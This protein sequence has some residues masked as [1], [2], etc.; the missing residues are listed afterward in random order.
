[1]QKLDNKKL[2]FYTGFT[3]PELFEICFDYVSKEQMIEGN[4]YKLPL[5]K[6]F[7]AGFLQIFRFLIGFLQ[8]P[9]FLKS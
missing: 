2:E 7:S 1:M 6:Q 9:I 5:F 8:C 4:D 3:S